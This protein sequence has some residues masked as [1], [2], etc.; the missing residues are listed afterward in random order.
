MKTPSINYQK[1][2]YI[3]FIAPMYYILER[4]FQL[5]TILSGQGVIPNRR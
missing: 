5:N 2:Q 4:V 3:A 1:Y